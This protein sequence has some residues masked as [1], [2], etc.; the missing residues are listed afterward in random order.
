MT[1][2][3]FA[4]TLSI[5]SLVLGLVIFFTYGFGYS[6]IRFY[7]GDIVVILFLY[8][9]LSFT[10]LNTYVKL[11]LLLVLALAVEFSQLIFEP[12]PRNALEELTIGSTF[13][14]VD[15]YMYLI[16]LFASFVLTKASEWIGREGV[17]GGD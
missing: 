14:V 1:R 3:T 5:T 13:D 16:G 17:G 8:G 7:G 9:L 4:T 15:I 10:R 6:D 2:V 11:L 12:E